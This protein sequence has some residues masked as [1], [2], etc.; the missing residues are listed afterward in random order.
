MLEKKEAA[1]AKAAE[2]LAREDARAQDA[3]DKQKA[4]KTTSGG[5]RKRMSTLEKAGNQ[6]ARSA[7][8]E[9]MRYVLRGIFG[10]RKR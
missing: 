10:S 2:R 5:G 7:G 6:A 1:A 8:R 4:R 3:L 9:A